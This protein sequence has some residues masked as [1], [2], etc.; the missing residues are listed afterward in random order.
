MSGGSLT[1]NYYE[2]RE[3]MCANLKVFSLRF[4]HRFYLK[5]F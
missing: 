3:A 5:E 1:V 2:Y 4:Y